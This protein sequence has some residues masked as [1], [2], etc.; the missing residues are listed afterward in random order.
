MQDAILI[1]KVLDRSVKKTACY[2]YAQCKNHTGM[3]Y[4]KYFAKI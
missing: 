2:W 1:A 4:N 3:Q